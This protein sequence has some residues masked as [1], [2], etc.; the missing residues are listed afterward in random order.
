MALVLFITGIAAALFTLLGISSPRRPYFLV[1]LTFF[2]AWL[3]GDLAMFHLVAQIIFTTVLVAQGAAAYTTGKVGLACMVAS[4]VGLVL[5]LRRHRLAA[6]PLDAALAT[7]LGPHEPSVA[8]EPVSLGTLLRPFVP[9]A[10]GVRIARDIV[11]GPHRRNRLDVFTPADGRTGCPVLLQIHGGAWIIGNKKQQ[12][13]PLMRHLARRG[14]V[15]VAINY[16]L[17]PRATFPEH[18]ID[19]KLALA[20][21]REHIGEYGGDP[22]FLAVTGG[23]AGGH[24]SALVGLTANDPR[25]QPGF[26]HADTSV[27]ACVPIYGV[28]DF[29][30][31]DGLHKGLMEP[32]LAKL[33]MKSRPGEATDAWHAA[34]P[35]SQVR[36]D[37]PP[38]FIIQGGQD[39]LVWSEE[40]RSFAEAL[41]KVST[42]AVAY[43]E[44][45][46]AQHAFDIMTTRRSVYAVR[47]ITRF[48]DHAR[49]GN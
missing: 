6:A 17:S 8:A 10:K 16:R 20:W 42:N 32:M 3:A 1:P 19:A 44:I 49:T 5:L 4:W 41:G 43:A 45:P 39:T 33:V 22:S 21:I 29:L 30:D 47:A 48:L 37:A 12:A 46:F 7:V 38:F 24:L 31:R 25:F 23:S 13:Q 35:L 36:I 2:I 9:S 11:Y 27:N 18:L 28:F 34:S 15:C 40:A 26:E 14:W